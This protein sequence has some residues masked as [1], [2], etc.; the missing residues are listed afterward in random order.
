MSKEM[1][2]H[3]IANFKQHS[4]IIKALLQINERLYRLNNGQPVARG[5]SLQAVENAAVTPGT[6]EKSFVNLVS[7]PDRTSLS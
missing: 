4:T 7:R 5:A 1:D 3:Q 2:L 6:S